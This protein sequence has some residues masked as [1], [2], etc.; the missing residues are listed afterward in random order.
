MPPLKAQLLLE[1]SLSAY[2][3]ES[4][5]NFTG[6]RTSRLNRS[7]AESSQPRASVC[8]ASEEARF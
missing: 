3:P 7:Y 4:L 1:E 5:F 8:K 6:I 2:F